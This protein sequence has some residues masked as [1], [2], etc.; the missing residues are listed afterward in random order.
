MVKTL[1]NLLLQNQETFEAES[2]YVA[3]ETQVLPDLHKWWQ[4]QI[5]I[6]K[7][8]YGENIE[9]SISQDLMY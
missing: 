3:F 1:K 8:L 5:C 2:Y 7:H 9:K 4:G 6:P